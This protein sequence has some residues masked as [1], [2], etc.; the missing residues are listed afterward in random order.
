MALYFTSEEAA[1]EGER[2]EPPPELKA[3]MDEM[4]RLSVGE[5]EFFD[6]EA[7]LALLPE[8]T[9]RAAPS[10]TSA[11]AGWSRLPFGVLVGVLLYLDPRVGRRASVRRPSAPTRKRRPP[12]PIA[13]TGSSRLNP[14]RSGT[15]SRVA[16]STLLGV[17]RSPA[18]CGNAGAHGG[19]GEIHG[20][21]GSAVRF[22]RGLHTN[23]QLRPGPSS[24]LL[25]AY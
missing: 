9:R 15:A 2:K 19:E 13:A 12:D 17:P 1:R 20:K 25:Y 14:G 7:P 16:L 10:S 23:Q 11:E 21:D 8:V 6:P 18:T 24:G 4:G 3:Q 5:P 22:R